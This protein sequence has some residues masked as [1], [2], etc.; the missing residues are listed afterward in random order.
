MSGSV[1]SLHLCGVQREGQEKRWQEGELSKGPRGL[2][3]SQIE[4][5]LM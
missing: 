4:M 1:D 5:N 2:R 3:F